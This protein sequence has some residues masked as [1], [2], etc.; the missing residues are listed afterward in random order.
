MRYPKGHEG[1]KM[2]L[3]KKYFCKLCNKTIH[4]CGC[5]PNVRNIIEKRGKS[6]V[7]LSDKRFGHC[8]YC[9]EYNYSEKDVK[10]AVKELKE[11]LREIQL[12]DEDT[13]I[14]MGNVAFLLD[15]IFGEKL[16]EGEK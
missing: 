10:L 12:K 9:R 7:S 14:C 8:G 5:N 2:S 4:E 13:S 6:T 16:C 11:R 1:G 3:S 15:E